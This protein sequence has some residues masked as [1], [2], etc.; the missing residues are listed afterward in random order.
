M[1]IVFHIISQRMLTSLSVDEMLLP[2]DGNRSTNFRDLRL[3]VKIDPVYLK[4]IH[5]VLSSFT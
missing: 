3:R 5:S 4:P 1:L 2:R